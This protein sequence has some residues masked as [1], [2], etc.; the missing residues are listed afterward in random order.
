MENN[1]IYITDAPRSRVKQIKD[2]L[3]LDLYPRILANHSK[4][5]ERAKAKRDLVEAER[6][7]IEK[8][9][10]KQRAR[11]A[12]EDRDLI[13]FLGSLSIFLMTVIT[14]LAALW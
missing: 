3:D 8:E 6:K 11:K 9:I 2:S 14:V 10:E 5:I 13:M 7:E 12:K 4:H 1:V